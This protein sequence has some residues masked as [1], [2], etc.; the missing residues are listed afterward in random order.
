MDLLVAPGIPV[1]QA[2]QDQVAQEDQLENLDLVGLLDL[3][4]LLVQL[5][6]KANEVIVALQEDQEQLGHQGVQ[7]QPGHK[8]HRVP[9]EK[10]DVQEKEV[11][12][13]YN[14]QKMIFQLYIHIY[15]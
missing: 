10:M 11:L 14:M 15:S 13:Y 6:Q 3:L 8:D 9:P 1:L 7:V 4:V 2:A 5:G 12:F